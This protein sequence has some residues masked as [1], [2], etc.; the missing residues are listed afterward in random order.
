VEFH[1][2][3]ASINEYSDG[4]KAFTGMI[5]QIIAG[6]PRVLLIDEPEAFLHPPLSYKLGKEISITANETGKSVFVSTHSSHF[7]M[8]CVQSGAQINIVRLTY[9]NGVPTARALTTEKL[10]RLIRH[11]LLRSTKVLEGLFYE[12]VI[13]TESDADRAFYEEINARLQRQNPPRGIPN[14]LFLNA[15]NKTT[16]HEIIR[17]LREMGIPAAGIVDVDILKDKG[18]DWTNFL[19]AGFVPDASHQGLGQTRSRIREEC[20][21]TGK[22]MKT[23]GGIAILSADIQEA[24]NDLFDQLGKYGLFAVRVGELE[25]WLR[26]LEQTTLGCSVSRGYHRRRFAGRRV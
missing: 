6:D 12:S 25:S 7:I 17:P 10:L 21:K 18:S 2:S 26:R 8:G 1:G 3:A 20:E 9:Q 5:T 16:I 11:P 22:E 4:V 14:C 23:Q 13:V 24:A 19:G 15:Q